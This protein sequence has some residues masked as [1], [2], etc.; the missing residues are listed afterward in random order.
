MTTIK[1]REWE[2]IVDRELTKQTY[3]KVEIGGAESCEC[4]DCKNFVHN[5]ETIFPDEIKILFD[6][7]GI[8]FKK[9][10]EICHYCRQKDGLHFYG[11]WFHY[12]GQFKGKDCTLPKGNNGY[13]LDLTPINDKFSIGFHYDSSL[14]YFDN[15]EN[16]VQI[17]FDAKTLWTIE[18]ESESE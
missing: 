1:F 8:D 4:N 18:K 3:Q 11:G 17:E 13:S 10:S 16:L 12:K 6:N 14:T 9:D 7:L 15:K 5:R 2:L